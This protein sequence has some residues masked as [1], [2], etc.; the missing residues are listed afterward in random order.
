MCL[1]EWIKKMW[2]THTPWNIIQLQKKENLP[3]ETAWMDLEGI[4]LS[5]VSWATNTN[6]LMISLI[7]RIK[8]IQKISSLEM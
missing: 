5:K 7:C 4:M 8:H 1:D 2:Y 6:T 3:F